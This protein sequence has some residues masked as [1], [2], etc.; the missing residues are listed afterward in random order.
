MVGELD[1]Q[2]DAETKWDTVRGSA[3]KP[4]THGLV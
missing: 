4:I 1:E 3:P 2:L